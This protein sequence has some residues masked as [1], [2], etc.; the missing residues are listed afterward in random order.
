MSEYAV[1]VLAVD[2]SPSNHGG[3]T[4]V[5]TYILLNS[6]HLTMHN[7]KYIAQAPS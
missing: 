7:L 4:E 3:T 6:K 2:T 1:P 5:H